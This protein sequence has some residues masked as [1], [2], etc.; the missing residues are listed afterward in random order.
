MNFRTTTVVLT[1]AASLAGCAVSAEGV[2]DAPAPQPV[3]AALT[4]E[5]AS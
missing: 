1:L 5:T 3:P 2:D 4:F